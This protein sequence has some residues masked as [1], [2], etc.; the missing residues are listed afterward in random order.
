MTL[1]EKETHELTENIKFI[2]ENKQFINSDFA[3]N[4]LTHEMLEGWLMFFDEDEEVIERLGNKYDLSK[5]ED[6]YILES[7]YKKFDEVF[8]L[9][10]V[11]D[12]SNEESLFYC[13]P[14]KEFYRRLENVESVLT[15]IGCSNIRVYQSSSNFNI[16]FSRVETNKEFAI[17]IEEMVDEIKCNIKR[18]KDKE[19][20]A[21]KKKE[22]GSN[23]IEAK[24]KEYEKLK[25]LFEKEDK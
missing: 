14:I 4:K 18:Q 12:R 9:N 22:Q 3:E 16:I 8:Q 25:A 17:R 10:N 19:K 24:R 7:E 6:G 13:V 20:R 1:S 5:D 23:S 2:R 21:K 11:L 15:S